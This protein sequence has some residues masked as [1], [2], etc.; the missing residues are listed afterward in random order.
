M[1]LDAHAHLHPENPSGGNDWELIINECR[2]NGVTHGVFS[3]LDTAAHYPSAQCVRQL[4]EISRKFRAFVQNRLEVIW[5]AYLN[6]QLEAWAKE[7]EQ[8][9]HAGA[10][11][12]KLWIALK[13]ADGSLARCRDVL[14]AAE[15]RR[16]P[17]LFHTYNRTGGNRP[18]EINFTECVRLAEQFPGMPIIAGHTG[19]N[20]RHSLELLKHA[21]PNLY[22]EVGGTAP[23]KGMVEGIVA[24]AGAERVLFGSDMPGRNQKAQLA[25][26]VFAEVSAET[27]RKILW[28]NAAA[29][30]NV[31][32]KKGHNFRLPDCPD[33]SAAGQETEDHFCFCGRWPFFP[34]ACQTPGELDAELAQRGITRAFC[35]DLGSIY[36]MDLPAANREFLAAAQACQRVKPLAVVNPNAENWPATLAEAGPGFAGI[37]IHPYLHNWRLD[38][39]AYQAFFEACAACARPIWI[40]CGLTDHRFRHAGVAPRPVSG[41][42]LLAFTAQAPQNQ[43]VFQ[44]VGANDLDQILRL[45]APVAKGTL[46]FA[47]SR[48]T[49][50][51]GQLQRIQAQHGAKALVMGTEFPFRDMRTVPWTAAQTTL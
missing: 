7:L 40:N 48:L 21:P 20:W 39:G 6:P 4:N 12:I 9:L 8:C 10:R 13:S 3:A 18:G 2:R 24:E 35:G 36:R 5:L 37:L 51:T 28:D 32:S 26:V 44:S 46:R 19:G 50:F 42:E 43:Y 30:F 45:S 34:T 22:M 29:I 38:D 41:A 49:D 31:R 15:A 17:V 14:A 47:I 16:L 1:I 23:E 27:R 11:G 33:L 25:K